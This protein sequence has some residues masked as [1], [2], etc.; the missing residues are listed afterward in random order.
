MAETQGPSLMN[1]IVT[2]LILFVR[3]VLVPVSHYGTFLNLFVIVTLLVIP[4]NTAQRFAITR[5][6]FLM[7]IFLAMEHGQ[8]HEDER[9]N[10]PSILVHP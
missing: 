4:K 3:F 6:L 9:K 10:K 1:W 2:F 5:V 8:Y 7:A